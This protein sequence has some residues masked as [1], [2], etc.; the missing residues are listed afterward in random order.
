MVQTAFLNSYANGL[1]LMARYEEARDA[2]QLEVELARDFSIDFVVPHALLMRAWAALGLRRF[3]Q[4]QRAVS[5]AWR[6]AQDDVYVLV[7]GAVLDAKRNLF[8]GRPDEALVSL[9]RHWQWDPMPAIQGEYFATKAL[10][11]SA[12]GDLDGALIACEEAAS[13]TDTME[14]HVLL[15]CVRAV[16]S[17][18]KQSPRS[19]QDAIRAFRVAVEVGNLDAF[20]SGYRIYPPLLA[21]AC[22]A[23][24]FQRHIWPLLSR[25]RDVPI[26]RRAGLSPHEL[27]QAQLTRREEEVLTL[28]TQG[29]TNREIAERLFVAEVTVK[30]HVRHI[31]AKLGVRSRTEAAIRAAVASRDT[32]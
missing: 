22:S 29:L 31:L 8:I 15:E 20:V 26:A 18:K 10:A 19:R 23:P 16:V 28:L 11:L 2:S 3:S 4:C 27:P 30:V 21:P 13:T 9:S 17:L 24:E 6:A 14:T 12:M 1:I 5:A 7:A 32:D 25:A